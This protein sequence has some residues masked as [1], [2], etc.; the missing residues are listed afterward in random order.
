MSKL[1]FNMKAD[2]DIRIIA[3]TGII[4]EDFD[5]SSLLENPGKVY[6]ID[7]N[8]LKMI[9]STGIREW[10]RFIEK[11]GPAVNFQYFNCPN[12]IIQQMNMV[13]GFL[14]KNAK[15]LSFF[16]PYFCEELDEEEHVLLQASE[17]KDF[18]APVRKKLVDGQEVEMEFDAIEEQYFKFLKR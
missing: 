4:D 3:M 16:A 8:E 5:Y 9:N 15:V 6:K 7:F 11:L 18:K 2:G 17:V 12:I 10:I 14:T 13:S 1:K